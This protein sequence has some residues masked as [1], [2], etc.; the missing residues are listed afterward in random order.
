[1]R[2]NNYTFPQNSR[3]NYDTLKKMLTVCLYVWKRF[4][5]T[6]ILLS[7]SKSPLPSNALLDFYGSVGQQRALRK[8][9][10]GFLGTFHCLPIIKKFVC[11]KTIYKWLLFSM[12]ILLQLRWLK[13]FLGSFHHNQIFPA[14]S[15]LKG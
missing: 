7:L 4:Y 8:Q 6:L 11:C 5:F 10:S 3:Q 14:V 12:K 15:V 2:E 1:M 13:S 9:N